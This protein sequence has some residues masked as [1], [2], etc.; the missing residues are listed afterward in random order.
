[1]KHIEEDTEHQLEAQAEK[2]RNEERER[3][4]NEKKALILNYDSEI[5][6]F[7]SCICQYEIVRI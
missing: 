4:L 5:A 3:W 6:T 2:I 1:M 7:K